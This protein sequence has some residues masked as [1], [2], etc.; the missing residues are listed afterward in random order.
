MTGMLVV[1]L[2]AVLV[3]LDAVRLGTHRTGFST[4]GFLLASVPRALLPVAVGVTLG[5]F[6]FKAAFAS[7]AATGSGGLGVVARSAASFQRATVAGVIAFIVVLAGPLVLSI[8]RK[9]AP[10]APA[11]EGP[12]RGWPLAAVAAAV[13]LATGFAMF[14]VETADR[15]AVGTIAPFARPGVLTGTTAVPP[16]PPA[17]A[18]YAGMTGRATAEMLDTAIAV[19]T[20]G[21][22]AL[23]VALI[24][25][26][27]ASGALLSRAPFTRAGGLAAQAIAVALVIGAGW[28][29]LALGSGAGWLRSVAGG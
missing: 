27:F 6:Q 26:S 12:R 22:I 17:Y 13:I 23:C 25:L 5:A 11:A 24:G 9:A 4:F 14:A 7:I 29:G 3:L 1:A 21:G 8:V 20:T 19:T 15:A 18:S 28:Y 10:A 16:I 2:V